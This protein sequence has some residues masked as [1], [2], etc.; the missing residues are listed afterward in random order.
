M[1]ERFDKAITNKDDQVARLSSDQRQ[2]LEG[3][4]NADDM[5][6]IAYQN[7]QT[8]AHAMGL[9]TTEEAQF[10][11]FSLGGENPSASA[12]NKLDLPKKIFITQLMGEIGKKLGKG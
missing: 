12:W 6:M 7:W 1:S 4:L 5:E 10:L 9:L 8:E 3:K 2:E 11:Y